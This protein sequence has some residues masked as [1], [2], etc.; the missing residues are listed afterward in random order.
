MK[1]FVISLKNQTDRRNKIAAL[2]D[3]HGVDYEFFDATYGKEMT[4]E[5]R[6]KC[7]FDDKHIV[8]MAGGRKLLVEDALSYPEFGCA[9]SHL[10]VYQ[11]ILDSNLEEAAIL[12]D[13]VNPNED[14]FNAVNNIS[15]IKEPW[16]VVHFSSHIGLK[17]LPFAK[18][19]SYQDHGD[20]FYF[21]RLGMCN[22]TLD[23]IFNR[24]RF[25]CFADFYVVNRKACQ[26][27]IELGY[28]VRLPADY[29]LGLVAYHNLKLFRAY[30]LNHF[31]IP[32]V[33]T[34]T[35]GDRP[36]HRMIRL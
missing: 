33:A 12:E 29:L 22:N 13:D 5:E 21:Q 23:A 28:P 20:T 31:V 24:R 8:E 25:L 1:Y 30:P 27:L 14:I 35:I 34:S 15:C 2:L 16:D 32:N 10:R 7:S 6:S 3:K 18:K 11:H 17:S 36:Q 19:Y 4:E 26:R 9:M